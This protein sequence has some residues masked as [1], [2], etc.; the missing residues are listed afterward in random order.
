MQKAFFDPK[1]YKYT[2]SGK[3]RLKEQKSKK[4]K[5]IIRVV[6]REL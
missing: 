1:L 2:T 6:I 3:R 5:V 4:I